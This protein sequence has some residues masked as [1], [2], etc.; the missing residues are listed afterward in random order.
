MTKLFDH[1]E[2]Q[3]NTFGKQIFLFCNKSEIPFI[4]L[5]S[6]SNVSSFWLT[7]RRCWLVFSICFSRRIKSIISLF[8]S[9]LI[10]A[11]IS[12]CKSGTSL[13]MACKTKHNCRIYFI[14]NNYYI[15]KQALQKVDMNYLLQN[16]VFFNTFF[17]LRRIH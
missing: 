4:L 12:D 16:L 14:R 7:V 13:S 5:F 1:V 9:E 6:I 15:I 2:R 11:S 10:I 17:Y 3:T 8:K